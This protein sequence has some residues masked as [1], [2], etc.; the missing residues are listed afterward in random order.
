MVC[1]SRSVEDVELY[2]NHSDLKPN[3]LDAHNYY[4]MHKAQRF[5]CNFSMDE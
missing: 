5:Y 2:A 4:D 3:R 1:K